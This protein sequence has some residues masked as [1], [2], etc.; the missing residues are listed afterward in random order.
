MTTLAPSFF[1]VFFFILVGNK[2]NHKLFDEFEIRQ[3]PTKEL[4]VGS[5]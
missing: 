1:I 5:P 2:D 3:D 4:T